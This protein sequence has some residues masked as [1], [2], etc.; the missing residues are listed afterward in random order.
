MNFV[1]RKS[2]FTIFSVAKNLSKKLVSGL[3]DNHIKNEARFY[4][5]EYSI[6]QN[7]VN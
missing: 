2:K 4:T 7:I 6:Y 5:D 3:M 1:D